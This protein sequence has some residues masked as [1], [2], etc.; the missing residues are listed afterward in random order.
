VARF[1]LLPARSGSNGRIRPLHLFFRFENQLGAAIDMKVVGY[2]ALTLSGIYLLRVAFDWVWFA[3][4]LV[5]WR[6]RGIHVGMYSSEVSS[7]LD[8]AFDVPHVTVVVASIP[9]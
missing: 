5:N 3:L 4:T 2:T 8:S 1:Q 9:R 7:V 6:P